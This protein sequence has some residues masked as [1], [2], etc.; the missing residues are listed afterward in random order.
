MNFNGKILKIGE[1]KSGGTQDKK[2]E[3]IDIWCEEIN[4]EHPNSFIFELWNKSLNGITPGNIVDVEYNA[5]ASEYNG[6]LNNH[7][8]VYKIG[9]TD[10]FEISHNIDGIT[11]PINPIDNPEL[12]DLPY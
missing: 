12:S 6:Y 11:N 2:W 3:K 10:N 5:K 4:K 9:R 8:Y 1:I 7:L